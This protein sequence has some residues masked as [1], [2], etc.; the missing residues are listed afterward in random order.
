MGV[1]AYHHRPVT[2]PL[3]PTPQMFALKSALEEQLKATGKTIIQAAFHL[4]GSYSGSMGILSTQQTGSRG[5]AQGRG[6]MAIVQPYSLPCQTTEIRQVIRKDL[7]RK[8][9]PV[10][11]IEIDENN[12]WLNFSPW[13]NAVSGVGLSSEGVSISRNSQEYREKVQDD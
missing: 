7:C 13:E 4:V 2:C 11:I 12:I 9:F 6:H 8:Q 5:A 1:F 10:R 3:H